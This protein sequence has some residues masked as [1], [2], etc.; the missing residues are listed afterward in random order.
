[1]VDLCARTGFG[2]CIGSTCVLATRVFMYWVVLC[3]GTGFGM[4]IGST[5][6]LAQGFL[7]M[8]RRWTLL[9]VCVLG[10]LKSISACIGTSL[11]VI[12]CMYWV[13]F[14]CH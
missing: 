1:M 5:C 14:G 4:C 6:V 8:G 10:R 11:G 13:V 2:L 3:A 7:C 12:E 9:S